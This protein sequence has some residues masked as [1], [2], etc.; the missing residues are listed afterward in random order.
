MAGYPETHQEA[1]SPQADLDNLKRKVDA[2]ADVIITQ[3]F[4][5]NADFFEW[6]ERCLKAGITTPIVPG[7]FPVISFKQTQRL[8]E[9]CGATIPD[10]L[11]KKLI[12]CNEDKEREFQVGVEHATAQSAELLESGI[13]GLHF[14]VLNQS[15]ATGS[16]LEAIGLP[17]RT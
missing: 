3:L 13:P 9:L 7:V 12:D 6:R 2:G 15:R 10:G 17:P 14:Y 4:Y 16:I 8:T 11:A 5:D 1:A